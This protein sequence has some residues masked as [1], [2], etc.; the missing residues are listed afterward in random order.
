MC[1]EGSRGTQRGTWILKIGQKVPRKE[2]RGG[3]SR[4]K[5]QHVQGGAKNH[6]MLENDKKVGLA[7]SVQGLGNSQPLG[8]KTTPSLVV[9]ITITGLLTVLMVAVWA[10]LIW[11]VCPLLM[12]LSGLIHL[13]AIQWD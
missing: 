8:T 12:V 11:A 9:Q 2:V 7:G 10:G 1:I 13:F 4:L 6:I 3:H 5:G